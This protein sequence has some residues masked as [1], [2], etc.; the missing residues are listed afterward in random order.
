MRG[1]CR[2][3]VGGIGH[4]ARGKS[5]CCEGSHGERAGVDVVRAGVGRC[6]R[7]NREAKSKKKKRRE[8]WKE[9]KGFGRNDKNVNGP[10]NT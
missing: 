9:G 1:I 7:K 3:R 8:D 4:V 6:E 10:G 2:S 5:A